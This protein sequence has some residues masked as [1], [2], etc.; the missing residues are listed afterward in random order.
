MLDLA[1]LKDKTY[2]IKLEDGEILHI[3]KPTQRMMKLVAEIHDLNKS[4]LTE[5]EKMDKIFDFVTVIFNH[6]TVDRKFKKAQLED[7]FD[8]GVASYVV[9]D[10]LKLTSEVLANPNL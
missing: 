8:I 9:Q 3:K 2:D 7:M 4:N 10:Y 6:N 1:I 5:I